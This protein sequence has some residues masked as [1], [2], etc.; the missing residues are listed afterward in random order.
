MRPV[1][2]VVFTVFAIVLAVYISKLVWDECRLTNSFLYCLKVT[3][4]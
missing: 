4:K 1:G 2:L 3:A